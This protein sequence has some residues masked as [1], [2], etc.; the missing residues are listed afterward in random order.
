MKNSQILRVQEFVISLKEYAQGV[1]EQAWKFQT[2][3]ILDQ[4]K[5]I[6]F[7]KKQIIEKKQLMKH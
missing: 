5:G 7:I 2:G 1:L 3:T 4:M 6:I